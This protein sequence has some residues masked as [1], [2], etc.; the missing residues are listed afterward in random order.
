MQTKTA[1]DP[2]FIIFST[3]TSVLSAPTIVR[4]VAVHLPQLV[5]SSRL[6]GPREP[7][8][9]IPIIHRNLRQSKRIF[10]LRVVQFGSVG[11]VFDRGMDSAWTICQLDPRERVQT[12]CLQL[13]LERR[14]V[15]FTS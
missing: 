10:D 14:P 15:R 1:L 7:R 12:R 3:Q 5:Q 6:H 11:K 9:S 2:N 8:R 4:S 13:S